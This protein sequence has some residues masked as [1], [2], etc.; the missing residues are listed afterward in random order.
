MKPRELDIGSVVQ[1]SPETNFPGCFMQVTESK[2]WGAQGF[3]AIPAKLG[4]Q[5]GH[6]YYR[7]NWENMEFIGM[8][9]WVP[10]SSDD[11][12]ATA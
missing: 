4:E 11:D 3:V 1:L 10:A 2:S 8:A 12:D 7:A 9:I 6:A 5:P